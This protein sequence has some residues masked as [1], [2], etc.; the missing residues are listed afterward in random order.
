M[1]KKTLVFMVMVA[2]SVVVIL[3]FV[4]WSQTNRKRKS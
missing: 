2:V 3:S 4:G 1:T